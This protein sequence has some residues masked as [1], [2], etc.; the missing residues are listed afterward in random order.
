MKVQ[1]RLLAWMMST[2]FLLQ[3]IPIT[4]VAADGESVDDQITSSAAT[5][6]SVNDPIAEQTD[7]M[8]VGIGGK[9][10]VDSDHNGDLGENENGVQGVKVKLY[11]SEGYFQGETKSLAEDITDE[12][13]QYEFE[14]LA[15]GEYRL[16][17]YA[18]DQGEGNIRYEGIVPDD[19]DEKINSGVWDYELV[20][21]ENEAD[22]WLVLVPALKA[23][24]SRELNIGIQEKAEEEISDSGQDNSSAEN[25]ASNVV[26]ND[27]DAVE[28]TVNE[29][30]DAGEEPAEESTQ[31][32]NQDQALE[33]EV[34]QTSEENAE[35]EVVTDDEGGDNE[36]NRV[37]AQVT[38]SNIAATFFGSLFGSGWSYDV[39]YVNASDK[40]DISLTEDGNV[41]YQIEFNASKDFPENSV[42]IRIPKILLKN[43]YDE[44]LLP[45]EIAVPQGT[46]DKPVSSRVS[47]FNYYIDGDD[48][49]FFNYKA[50]DA[51]TNVAFQVLYKNID[52]MQIKDRTKWSLDSSCKVTVN[53]EEQT[54]SA[55]PITGTVDT[56]AQLTGVSMTPYV[57]DGKS[58]SPGLYTQNQIT[59]IVGTIPDEYVDNFN[60]YRYVVWDVTVYGNATQPWD[61]Y[62]K[63]TALTGGKTAGQVVGFSI[64]APKGEGKYA[65]YY[66]VQP[67]V[68]NPESFNESFQVVIAYPIE[69]TPAGTE[70]TNEVEA[71]LVPVDGVDDPSA[72]KTES[73]WTYADYEW[74]YSGDEIDVKKYGGGTY[75][76]WL[77][78]YKA[79]QKAGEDKGNFDFTIQSSVR[80]Y[81]QTHITSGDDLG[82]LIEG[83]SYEAVTVDDFLYAYPNTSG[84]SGTDYKILTGEDYYFSSVTVSQT[85]QGYD[86]WEDEYAAAK[87]PECEGNGLVI[88]AMF[89]DSDTPDEWTKVAEVP[90]SDSGTMTY[91]F[92]Q[93]DIAKKP[94]RV[95][96]VHRTT[97]YST[98]CNIQVEMM[99]RHDSEAFS[100]FVDGISYED[101]GTKKLLTL[102]NIAGVMAQIYDENTPGAFLSNGGS[103][104]YKEPGL[105][106]ASEQLYGTLP[107]R[108]NAF[109]YL[110]SLEEHAEA[111]K[112]GTSWNDTI[113]GRVHLQYNLTAYD[114]YNVYG[115]EALNYL[116]SEGVQS[117]GRNEVVFYDLLPYGVK[118]DPSVEVTAGRIRKIDNQKTYQYYPPSWDKSQI[119]VTVDTEKDV[120]AD[121]KGSGRTMVIFHISYSGADA[122][123]Y[124]SQKWMEGF[125]V[126]FGAYYDWKDTQVVGNAPNIAAFMSEDNTP[127]LGTVDEVAKD[128]GEYPAAVGNPGAYK[129]LGA[130]I[131]QDGS[132]E[133][134]VLYAQSKVA[135]DSAQASVSGIQKLVRADADRFDVYSESAEVDLG[136]GYTYD[137]T[138]S[139]VS[140]SKSDIVVFDHLDQG[141]Q[142]LADTGAVF[143]ENQWQGTF[144]G[145]VTTGLEE[146]GIDPVVYYNEAPDAVTSSDTVSPVNVLT[147][148]NG[149]YTEDAWEE[150]GKALSDVRS[151][152]VDMSRAADGGEYVL[153]DTNA[154]SFQIRM[155]SP[156]EDMGGKAYNSAE[157]YAVDDASVPAVSMSSATVVTQH[158]EGQ[159]E[160]VKE[161][162][163]SIPDAV[164]DT[165]FVF[166]V[167]K[168][169]ES[170][171]SAVFGNQEYQ[172]FR[173]TQDGTWERQGEDRI[174]A[175]NASG[176]LTL[177]A[178]EKA[179]FE[180]PYARNL[181]ANEEENPFW[182]QTSEVSHPDEDTVVQKVTN[183]YRPVLYV[184]KELQA[185]PTECQDT[186]DEFTFRLLADGEPAADSE[187]W[188]V[189]S[190]RTDGGIPQKDTSRGDAG[191]GRTDENGEFTIKY[192]DII[193]VFP[194]KEGCSYEVTETE[195]SGDGTNWICEQPSVSGELPYNGASVKI[196]NIYKWK[197]LYISKELTNQDSEDCVQKFTF[198]ITDENGNPVSGKN[199]TLLE[200][201]LDTQTKGT[202]DQ[203][204]TFSVNCAGK[205]IRVDRLEGGKSY[206]IEEIDK[207]GY[208]D[209]D[210]YEPVNRTEEVLLPLY[211]S[212]AKV[213]FT[214]DYI[215]RDLS[216][217]KIVNYDPAEVTSEE[218]AEM[219]NRQFTMTAEVNGK[220]L[221]NVP[222]VIEENGVPVGEES[223]TDDKGTFAIK[224]GQTAVFQDV[225]PEGIEYKV[226]ETPDPDY[227]QLFPIDNKPAEGTFSDAGAD[228]EFINGDGDTFILE[229]GYV[230]AD[231]TDEISG[232]YLKEIKDSRRE[233]AAVEFRLEVRDENGSYSA[234]PAADT[235]V[236]VID[237]L[238]NTT[239]TDIWKAGSSYEALPWEQICIAGLG[240]DTAY[241]LSESAEDQHH[242]FRY[243]VDETNYTLE[244]SQKTP[245][246][247]AVLEGVV[248][249]KPKAEMINQIETLDIRSTVVKRMLSEENPVPDGAQLA[250]RV[251]R[252]DGQVW[253][254]AGN[255]SYIVTDEAGIISDRTETTGEDGMIL[256][257]KSANGTP[258]V[259]FIGCQVKV[260]PKDPVVGTLRVV[261]VEESTDDSWGR[262]AGYVNDLG[263]AS[264][265]VWD[266]IGFANSNTTH[267][268]EVEKTMDE[269][270]EDTFTMTLEQIISAAASPVTDKSQILET[271]PGKGIRYEIYDSGS[272]ERVGENVTGVKGEIY[273]KAGQYARLMLEDGTEW[274][275]T[276]K[277]PNGY[278]LGGSTISGD[279]K[280][281]SAVKL[282]DNLTV[283]TTEKP[284]ENLP[285][286][287]LT[288]EMVQE[289]V[290]NADTGKRVQLTEGSVTIPEKIVVDTER[291]YITAI[292]ASAFESSY[293]VNEED[294]TITFES[295]LTEVVIPDTVVEIGEAA[296][297]FCG[298]IKKLSLPDSIRKIGSQAFAYVGYA[299]MDTGIEEDEETGEPVYV[300]KPLKDGAETF[301]VPEGVLEIGDAAFS[302]STAG[303]AVIPECT[304]LGIQVFYS[305]AYLEQCVLSSGLKEI[306]SYTFYTCINPLFDVTIP[307]GVTT[308]GR[309]AFSMSTF[310]VELPD[311]VETIEDQAFSD[312]M[313]E[314]YDK[315]L[316]LPQNLKTI[317]E[318]AFEHNT[319][320]DIIW[321]ANLESVDQ[322]AFAHNRFVNITLP[323]GVELGHGSFY[324]NDYLET[325]EFEAG[326]EIIPEFMFYECPKLKSVTIPE[327]VT[328]IEMYAFSDCPSLEAIDIPETVEAIGPNA[329]NECT[330]LKEIVIPASVQYMGGRDQVNQWISKV[331]VFT[332]CDSLEKIIIQGE[333]RPL[334]AKGFLV[335]GLDRKWGAPDTTELIWEVEQEQN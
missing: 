324:Y 292:E 235:E 197:T 327:G 73:S 158:L 79:A 275:V 72:G 110:S 241:R 217:S 135:D 121:Y 306:P 65:D 32:E 251:E 209:G 194:G 268:F 104:N 257:H 244:I 203:D 195:G 175:T 138:V 290:I 12:L 301:K 270:T 248:Q 296:F 49:V 192:G 190:V 85:D 144:V 216:V 280:P 34:Q 128:N 111:G 298:N 214:N 287:T 200:D 156:A 255:I 322:F 246:N 20:L 261:E 293:T 71:V 119:S 254:P 22:E 154:L 218:L 182:E 273:L 16:E 98:K 4:A 213:T 5:D 199:W 63:N 167:Y 134:S 75:A 180:T 237:T 123:V 151:V 247:D 93:E 131:D 39:Y 326:T 58:Y 316:E 313:G 252:Y 103:D 263:Q 179:V 74:N 86:P 147:Q 163:G 41:K 136:E 279:S 238:T 243:A 299:Y 10:F 310:D 157:Y 87:Q 44:P 308:I 30:P 117:P 42:E 309:S 242:V 101:K 202:T 122:A 139:N 105:A 152:A 232:Q 223:V 47:P 81:E 328:E 305:C 312:Y 38:Q 169:D 222:Y 26:N 266:G 207:T 69:N 90:W 18:E 240:P 77:N 177:K 172:L 33:D 331:D 204:G 294:Y 126:S 178:D 219:Q 78:V 166:T 253:N 205:T 162:A 70:V 304:A 226:T 187:F 249:E 211:G 142:D 319:L 186:A 8:D 168:E 9:V 97:N 184:Q 127:L 116:K 300:V 334:N 212:Q 82:Q 68:R 260:H 189:D 11:E 262:F 330:S 140:G 302:A 51:G 102:E 53:G 291:Y 36:D 272:G 250:Y 234:W 183:K 95:K 1:K 149:W 37:A 239:S 256:M 215:L 43:R 220:A 271:V 206:I 19:M 285:G 148:E 164:K 307:E 28:S 66:K 17:F 89:A 88:Y 155:L 14:G 176:E 201:G 84:I 48:L 276:E 264:A 281:V 227:P 125:G 258:T 145:V 25:E 57:M 21:P 210:F 76:S 27:K 269:P 208:E 129:I 50:I 146:A 188:Y 45:I 288:K 6:E 171:K 335:S 23:L 150:A 185:V 274:T 100:E 283:I 137:I 133:D 109:L 83:K 230:L 54:K 170:G 3:G 282:E 99:I 64:P 284:R 60:Q 315:V 233:E 96:A 303:E 311:S 67:N 318:S 333:K 229:K 141:A 113:N 265:S 196:T 29:T 153:K 321:N 161:F 112:S 15:A 91:Q 259:E 320:T 106:E 295:K 314:V 120:I 61:L 118:F 277:V 297:R 245:A 325:A 181:S 143:D 228:V 174:Y 114:G 80:G 159:Y 130:D 24:Q 165:E 198:K 193:A 46:A 278:T 55:D 221:S 108:R 329:F 224:N 56:T 62:I 2:V 160:L 132:T 13:G 124:T 289:G 267:E 191:I 231:Q 107:M 7:L 35:L 115:E 92:T 40:K 332:G 52:V 173:M 236:L 317:G 323:A 31:D 286:I 225:A 94:W 59:K